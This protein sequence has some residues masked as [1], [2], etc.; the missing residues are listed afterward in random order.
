MICSWLYCRHAQLEMA[1]ILIHMKCVLFS[2]SGLKMLVYIA[3]NDFK[4][5]L[6]RTVWQ[7]K[8]TRLFFIRNQFIRNWTLECQKCRKKSLCNKLFIWNAYYLCNA[9]KMYERFMTYNAIAIYSKS[10]ETH[11][12]RSQ[13]IRNP[14]FLIHCNRDVCNIPC[15]CGISLTV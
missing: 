14:I 15:D 2:I 7:I 13:G 1:E 12:L 4:A 9:R 5:F 6:Y 3:I 8:F 11:T 10:M